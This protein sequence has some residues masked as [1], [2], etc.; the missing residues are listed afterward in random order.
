MALELQ[1]TVVE[2]QNLKNIG[3]Q[4]IIKKKGDVSDPFAVIEFDGQK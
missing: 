2:A 4:G 1:V 3:G